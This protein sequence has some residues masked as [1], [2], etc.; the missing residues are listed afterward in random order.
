M[1]QAK[2]EEY[3]VLQQRRR[4]MEYFNI[5]PESEGAQE[6][7]TALIQGDM[8]DLNTQFAENVGDALE[9][10]EQFFKDFNSQFSPFFDEYTSNLDKLRELRQQLV[11]VLNLE[12]YI[13]LNDKTAELT[14][15]RFSS[16]EGGEKI[17]YTTIVLDEEGHKAKVVD[18]ELNTTDWSVEMKKAF[19][20]GD[21]EA[22]AK[23]AANRDKKINSNGDKIYPY[24]QSNSQL[25]DDWEDEYDT[26]IYVAPGQSWKADSDKTYEVN[27]YTFNQTD[28]LSAIMAEGGERGA[29][30]AE[31]REQKIEDLGLE[32]VVESN[33]EL[34][35]A[36]GILGGPV[37]YT[38]L[39]M[40]HGTPS[41]PEYVLNSDQ[42][43]N[44]LR[45]FSTTQP[46]IASTLSAS[47]DTIYQLSGD[48]V[49]NGVNDPEEF[50][51]AVT[52]AMDSRFSVTKNK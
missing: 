27:G 38:G 6:A 1:L 45:Y 49:L 10:Q 42:A 14:G 20:S 29:A 40:L 18:N 37:T 35:Y 26:E 17:K 5:D 47:N 22:Y 4:L 24:V 8:M 21:E 48:I 23:A 43:Y 15:Q 39:T 7:L 52:N 9:N 34:G 3:E 2:Y 28:D 12:D 13:K 16:D 19:L 25:R 50:W 31:A 30:A 41:E 51:E 33:A 11:D 32:G 44:L 36:K 46:E